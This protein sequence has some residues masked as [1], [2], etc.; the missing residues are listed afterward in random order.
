MR[1]IKSVSKV[2]PIAVAEGRRTLG[3]Y[4]KVSSSLSIFLYHKF[5]SVQREETRTQAH[6]LPVDR[7]L[8]GLLE[9]IVAYRAS[10][11]DRPK[12]GA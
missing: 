3:T 10:H 11:G 5:H 9:Q 2:A 8:G 12:S 6:S 4:A 7:A 1:R